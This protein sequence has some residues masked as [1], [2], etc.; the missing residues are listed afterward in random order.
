[1]IRIFFL[2]LA[3]SISYVWAGLTPQ[4]DLRYTRIG[5][6]YVNKK[7]VKRLSPEEQLQTRA[8]LVS[9]WRRSEWKRSDPYAWQR[10][11]R[12][13]ILPPTASEVSGALEWAHKRGI[14]GK[15]SRVAVMEK[16]GTVSSVQC[17]PKTGF[18]DVTGLGDDHAMHVAD[19]I[20][21]VAP[22][23]TIFMFPVVTKFYPTN[24]PFIAFNMSFTMQKKE[25]RGGIASQ[26]IE[27]MGHL[28]SQTL[29]VRAA[30]NDGA[31]LTP[32]PG[33]DDPLAD[34]A[35]H[36]A[37]D[38]EFSQS[39]I[40]VGALDHDNRPLPNSNHPGDD[41]DIQDCFIWTLGKK[42]PGF[43]KNRSI[44]DRESGTSLAAP[45]AT[46]LIALLKQ[47]YP[48]FSARQIREIILESAQRGFFIEGKT[49]IYDPENHSPF[50]A[51]RLKALQ[52]QKIIQ[53]SFNRRTYGK[54][55]L[56]ARNAFVYGDLKLEHSDWNVTQ[57]RQAMLERL[58]EQDE[59]M[60]TRIQKKWREYRDQKKVE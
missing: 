49:Y 36:F 6:S 59:K 55:I 50:E 9:N 58:Q 28:G 12:E 29:F 52:D 44:Q 19:I 35:Y 14:T 4:Q 1:M 26:F 46:G 51:Q 54:G 56:S 48:D 11:K 43:Q 60:A 45:I 8:E 31:Y 7:T 2:F 22:D 32:K 25:P 10:A 41:N 24:T 15:G 30:G 34:I 33:I 40:L 5:T 13:Y 3:V 42:V 23:C 21:Q 16:S 18:L 47:K 39:L 38:K 17:D 20:R 37:K 57:L 27:G 53:V